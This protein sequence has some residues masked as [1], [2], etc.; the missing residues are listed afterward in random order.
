MKTALLVED[1]SMGAVLQTLLER[2]GIEA[3]TFRLPSS[4]S[5]EQLA[6]RCSALQRASYDVMVVSA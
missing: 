2:A 4:I 5:E 6:A 1:L 3:A